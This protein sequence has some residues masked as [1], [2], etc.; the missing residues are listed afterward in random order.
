MTAA[1]IATTATVEAATITRPLY[2]LYLRAKRRP[3]AA[4][5]SS[6]ASTAAAGHQQRLFVNPGRVLT[7]H[8][9][10]HLVPVRRD[11]VQ[12]AGGSQCGFLQPGVHLFNVLESLLKAADSLTEG[13][14]FLG[15][16]LEIFQAQET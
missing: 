14:D 12:G 3:Q 8:G 1:A 6:A 7:A 10:I 5:F 16:R 11:V 13:T 4:E 2:H 15:D 9:L